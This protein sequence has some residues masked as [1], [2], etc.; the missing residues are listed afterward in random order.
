MIRRR[1]RREIRVARN[2]CARTKARTSEKLFVNVKSHVS[3]RHDS[4]LNLNALPRRGN[5]G[6]EGREEGKKKQFYANKFLAPLNW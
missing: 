2:T 3:S 1:R 5:M 6:A 4:R